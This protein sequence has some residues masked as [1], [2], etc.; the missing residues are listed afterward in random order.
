MQSIFVLDLEIGI[1]P[2]RRPIPN[3]TVSQDA[4][5]QTKMMFQY[6]QKSA[7]YTYIKYKAHYDKKQT[8][9]S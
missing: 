2:Q 1:C 3:S 9:P 5:E 8:L 4:R 7:E 6:A